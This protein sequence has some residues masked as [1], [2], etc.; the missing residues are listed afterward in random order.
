MNF[1]PIGKRVILERIENE[2]TT[3]G[4]IIVPGAT[5]SNKGRV[6]QVGDE[7]EGI[8]INDTVVYI[9]CYEVEVDKIEYPVVNQED[10]LGI[11][12]GR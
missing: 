11:L 1:K 10:I 12:K 8:R 3:K 5:K 6:L 9:K 4:G 2:E 7:I